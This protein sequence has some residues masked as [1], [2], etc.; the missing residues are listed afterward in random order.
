MKCLSGI[1]DFK[2]EEPTVVTIGKFDGR[3][4]GHQKLLEKM[5]EIKKQYGYQTAVYTFLKTPGMV[6]KKESQNVLTTNAER[7][8]TMELMGI[9]LLIEYPF[10]EGVAQMLPEEFIEKI[11]VGQM[12]ARAIVVGPDCGFGYQRSGNVELLT[13]LAGRYG[14]QLIVVEKKRDQDREISSTYI[15]EQLSVGN[16]EKVNELLGQPYTISGIV[17]H[18]NH[19]GGPQLGFPTVNLLPPPEKQL[20][21]FGVYVS[22]VLI[23]DKVYG[24]ITNIGQKPTIGQNDPVGVETYLFDF[25]EDVYGQY[26]EVRLLHFKRPEKKFNNFLLLKEQINSDKE[27]GRQYLREH[28]IQEP[29][30]DFVHQF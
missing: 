11:L 16:I 15:R 17:V 8:K 1:R 9:D 19:I 10:S 26:I 21:P 12:N 22:R 7:R 23:G 2:I 14:Y 20:P 18:G 4:K 24:G 3:H 30:G 13:Q 5:L 28:T 25:D 29:Y 6:V 27:Y